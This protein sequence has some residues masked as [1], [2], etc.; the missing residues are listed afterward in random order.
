MKTLE[1]YSEVLEVLL[2]NSSIMSFQ[3]KIRKVI[4][5]RL[6]FFNQINKGSKIR[7]D[8]GKEY[9]ISIIIKTLEYWLLHKE[10]IDEEETASLI[11]D[12]YN[13]GILK[14]ININ[15]KDLQ[16]FKTFQS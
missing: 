9:L 7:L 2:T 8:L 14:A 3:M 12:V 16:K 5:N 4:S 1:Q 6:D 13:Y 15:P 10:E 11:R